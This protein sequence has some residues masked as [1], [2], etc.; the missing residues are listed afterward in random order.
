MTEAVGESFED[1]RKSFSYGSRSDL[2]FKFLKNLSDEQA[3]RFL[4]QLLE[5]LGD[6][7]DSGEL[8]PLIQLA[9]EAQVEGYAP[10]DSPTRWAYEDRPF[11]PLTK[12]LASCRVGLLTSSGHFKA[13]DDPEPLGVADMSQREAEDRIGEFLREAPRLSAIPAD[14]D[15]SDLQVRHGG[16][17]VR[18]VRKDHNVAFPR[19]H[20]AAAARAGRIGELAPT[21]YS[22]TGA[23]AQGRV[24]RL[25][26]RW[27]Q[28]LQ[29]D[30]V[31]VVLL[32]P[33]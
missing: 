17:D 19:D 33:V 14:I 6:S 3:A 32:V 29:D 23:A 4:Q 21:L 16:Y 5:T 25:A 8:D 20:L 9:Y 15:T 12:P 22:F 11:T 13:G 24:K 2:S 10:G 7:Y 31:D 28:Q 26:P 30:A 27:A 1:F 18:S